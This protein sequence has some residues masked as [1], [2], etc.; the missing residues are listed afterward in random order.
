MRGIGSGRGNNELRREECDA[1]IERAAR[2][3][4]S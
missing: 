3:M 2:R 4:R 1:T